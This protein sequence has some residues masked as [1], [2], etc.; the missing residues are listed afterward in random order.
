MNISVRCFGMSQKETFLKS[1][2][3]ALEK[4][5]KLLLNEQFDQSQFIIIFADNDPLSFLHTLSNLVQEKA[6]NTEFSTLIIPCNLNQ[7]YK[8]DLSSFGAL[9]PIHFPVRLLEL[10]EIIVSQKL[11]EKDVRV[12]LIGMLRAAAKTWSLVSSRNSTHSINIA[13]IWTKDY[14]PLN[15]KN[16]NSPLQPIAVIIDDDKTFRSQAKSKL[17]KSFQIFEFETIEQYAESVKKNSEIPAATSVDVFFLDIVNQHR[18]GNKE[19]V[20]E[21]VV[22]ALPFLRIAR[23]LQ[24]FPLIIML[25]D[26]PA[27]DISHLC[28]RAGANY[29]LEKDLFLYY[30]DITDYLSKILWHL[31]IGKYELSKS[32]PNKVAVND[33]K[34]WEWTENEDD[35]ELEDISYT[36]KMIRSLYERDFHI[37]RVDLL[38]KF[39]GGFGGGQTIAIQPWIKKDD[40]ENKI[41]P[42]IV[43]I[44]R[45]DKM[46][47][48]WTAYHHLIA[49]NTTH[50]FARIE[51]YFY[52]D[53][54]NAIIAYTLAGSSNAYDAGKITD[55]YE[56]LI[57]RHRCSK[58]IP[59][60]LFE[61]ILAQ[62]HSI[63]YKPKEFD[64]II[65]FMA[66]ELEPMKSKTFTLTDEKSEKFEISK[67]TPSKQTTEIVCY[68]TDSFSLSKFSFQLTEECSKW[69]LRR[70]KTI[71]GIIQDDLIYSILTPEEIF[72]KV[73]CDERKKGYDDKTNARQQKFLDFLKSNFRNQIENFCSFIRINHNQIRRHLSK[74]HWR[75]VHGDLNIRNLIYDEESDNFWL[76]D[77]ANTREGP[78]AIDFIVFEFQIRMYLLC[79]VMLN[80]L[81][82][83]RAH[84]WFEYA[85]KIVYKFEHILQNSNRV[86]IKSIQD[87]L[88]EMNIELSGDNLATFKLGWQ[89][90]YDTR[91]LAFKTFYDS[92]QGRQVY[93]F[94]F[95]LFAIRATQKFK[96]EMKDEK[97]PLGTL[98]AAHAFKVATERIY[99]QFKNWCE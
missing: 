36:I 2:E 87:I 24:T 91:R 42:R 70:K 29:Y 97:G 47:Q 12:D 19:S 31:I 65:R 38:E 60:L 10:I 72:G 3:R 6:I 34:R 21:G 15:L 20:L 13:P 28:Y 37:N 35:R 33:L 75:V 53:H 64:D 46:I 76:I 85:E 78:P 96:A 22:E 52:R 43:K 30:P 86:K 90:I 63:K 7:Q 68:P 73:F 48:E 74:T 8:P 71:N 89:I 40:T 25:S 26:L 17:D 50:S 93:D 11:I 56:M 98:W 82:S 55:S 44:N 62:L 67:V 41:A 61:S 49:T 88:Q 39:G 18:D 80:I 5:L 99:K 77:F 66:E 4:C 23:E 57:T 16:R 32:S 92:E 69:F 51:P 84:E 54:H 94:I 45:I 83:F 27:A 79:P 1:V 95:A 58:K 81:D 9:E 59:H 14:D